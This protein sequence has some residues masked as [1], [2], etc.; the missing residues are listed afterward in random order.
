MNNYHENKALGS[1]AINCLFKNPPAQ[2][3]AEYIDKIIKRDT[4]AMQFGTA[5][6]SR[7]LEPLDYPSVVSIEP[8]GTNR[9]TKGYKEWI[10]G[11]S[12]KVVL[13]HEES[14]K[15]EAMFD[16]LQNNEQA[17]Q[18][19]SALCEVEKPLF[20]KDKVHNIE[21]KGKIDG[22]IEGENKRDIIIDL[23][24]T[25]DASPDGFSRAMADYGIHRQLAHYREGYQMIT[26]RAASCYIIAIEKEPPYLNAVYQIS[27]DALATGLIERNI[28]LDTYA[29]CVRTGEWGGYDNGIIELPRW[30]K[31][32]PIGD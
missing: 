6:H 2:F 21:L 5:L 27:E 10:A 30:Y 23:K 12:G 7:V 28:A 9:R 25:R 4:K 11:Q 14:E 8:E 19:L 22:L 24:T 31:Y 26:G 17:Y 29:K 3:K 20:W 16:A 1:S 15:I 13:K 32:T 18:F